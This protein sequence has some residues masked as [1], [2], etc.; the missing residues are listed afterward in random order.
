MNSQRGGKQ[1]PKRASRQNK[2][3]KPRQAPKSQTN[4]GG[5]YGKGNFQNDKLSRQVRQQPQRSV[6]A[7]YATGQSQSEPLIS[8]GPNF[9]RIVHKE[10]LCNLV[11]TANYTVS[12]SFP[13]N[14]GMT[15]FLRWLP[16]QA[17]GWETYHWNK[18]EF[19]SLT[20]TGSNVPGSIALI[21][22]YDA[23]DPAPT[24]E[25]SASSYKDLVE[26][27][28]WKD[29]CCKLPSSRL[30][31]LGKQL[32]IRYGAVSNTDIKTYDAGN[33]FITTTDGTAVAWSKVW[34]YYDVTL[35][36][37][38]LPPGGAVAMQNILHI[39]GIT[40]TTANSFPNQ[41]ITGNA[42]LA[43]V[44]VT[45][46]IITFN[47]PGRYMINYN[48]ESTTNTV[49]SSPTLGGGATYVTTYYANEGGGVPGA[50]ICGSA[51][52]STAQDMCINALASSTMTFFN[53]VVGGTFWDLSIIL[54]NSLTN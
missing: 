33:L 4:G 7:A 34:A 29:I 18:I 22:D 24:D 52:A 39:T 5:R 53:T 46:N 3:Q 36:T 16:T 12:N 48:T 9:V 43:S 11:G 37:P 45:G 6:A 35:Y 40:E 47:V 21:P 28:P 23:S 50:S 20:R 17:V 13:L 44:P 8:R 54:I 49:G 10:L 32:F 42:G 30:H 19:K 14:P 38:Q 2:S 51:A 26:D 31:P 41:T 27:V 1:A 15:T 25:F